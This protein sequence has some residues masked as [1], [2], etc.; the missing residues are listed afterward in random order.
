M[1]PGI[2]GVSRREDVTSRF[3]TLGKLK[4]GAPK[5]EGL[6]DLEYF[7]FDPAKDDA[8]LLQAFEDAYGPEPQVLDRVYLPY[9]KMEQCFSSWRELYGQNGLCK[10]R[11]NGDVIVDW[12]EGNR[13]RHGHRICDKKFKDTE[14]RCPDCPLKPVGRLE[15]ILPELWE[16]GY[17]G[18]VTLETHSWNDIATIAGKLV[19]WEPLTG[20]P[21]KLWREDTR[22]GVPI[23]DRRAAMEHSLIKLELTDERLMLEF[24]AAKRRDRERIEGPALLEPG[25]GDGDAPAVLIDEMTGEI[26]GE[27]SDDG[28]FLYEDIDY[29]GEPLYEAEQP[30]QPRAK[31][32]GVGKDPAELVKQG[33]AK[34]A[35]QPTVP[36]DGD[37]WI[38]DRATQKRF[39]D[40]AK[41]TMA[42]T[43]LDVHKAIGYDHVAD[44]PGEKD[45]AAALIRIYAHS[46]A[47]NKHWVDTEKGAAVWYESLAVMELS[48]SVAVHQMLGVDDIHDYQGSLGDALAALDA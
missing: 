4:K 33:E 35:E 16:A 10:V 19:Q 7:R 14:N 5:S 37:H 32:A 8:A 28:Q 12:I 9:D 17:I 48:P 43:D 30:P 40:W 27:L 42:L 34:M 45:D 25:Q 47:R 6:S 24:E 20:R 46:H 39:W 1:E 44:F 21:F 15:I 31:L 22:I 38:K 23:K 26:V 13:H 29:D 2:I 11:C 18:L 41:N 36:D 3:K